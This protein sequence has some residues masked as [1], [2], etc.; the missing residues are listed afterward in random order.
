MGEHGSP[1]ESRNELEVF[2]ANGE[3]FAE[4]DDQPEEDLDVAEF[5]QACESCQEKEEGRKRTK[6]M[7]MSSWTSIKNWRRTHGSCRVSVRQRLQKQ[8]NDSASAKNG[9]SQR[10][11]IRARNCQRLKRDKASAVSKWRPNEK[12]WTRKMTE[13]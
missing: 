10:T 4:A 3:R 5:I 6:R 11:R 9:A 13:S 2:L 8:M 1:R 12:R 7:Q